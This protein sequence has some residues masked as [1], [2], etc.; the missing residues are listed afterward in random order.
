MPKTGFCS[1]LSYVYTEF[2]SYELFSDCVTLIHNYLQ[3]QEMTRV[4]KSLMKFL[5]RGLLYKSTNQA[6]EPSS[7]LHLPEVLREYQ[8]NENT[9]NNGMLT[10]ENLLNNV[11]IIPSSVGYSD[12]YDYNINNLIQLP[13]H[14]K[15]FYTQDVPDSHI[16]FS[17]KASHAFTVKHYII[18]Q[19]WM[20]NQYKM[21]SWVILG[22]LATSGDWIEIDKKE[23]Q[24]KF[25]YY[26]VRYFPIKET[27]QLT[28]VK[29][30]Q[31]DETYDGS[32]KLVIGSFDI[33]GR[34]IKKQ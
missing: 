6:T 3:T 24:N 7:R 25:S 5:E 27:Q 2:C 4:E 18:G 22:Q 26:E 10:H 21:K 23:N 16:T 8:F 9:Y 15:F 20:E 17:L 11:E 14:S 31:I 28:A 19:N 13:L 33:Y 32:N 30:M 1:L 34:V 29:L 12:E